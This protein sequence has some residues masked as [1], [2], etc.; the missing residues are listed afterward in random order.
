MIK[1]AVGR[2]LK[3]RLAVFD[4][5]N[6]LLDGRF[7]FA[8]AE[9]L[10]FVNELQNIISRNSD[11]VKRAELIAMMLIGV[12]SEKIIEIADSIN[13]TKGVLDTVDSLKQ[14]GYLTGIITDSYDIV[15]DLVKKKSA[16]DFSIGIHLEFNENSATG[17]IAIP[18]I[19]FKSEISQCSHHYCKGHAFVNAVKNYIISPGDT[20]AVGDGANDLCMIKAAGTGIAFCSVSNDL[21]AEASIRIKEKNLSMILDFII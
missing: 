13:L 7:I 12:N 20:V 4:M 21:N 19:Y 6:T 18:D 10:G 2:P 5:D 8:A 9:I 3:S 14:K 16:I 15:A 1:N 17:K 11:P